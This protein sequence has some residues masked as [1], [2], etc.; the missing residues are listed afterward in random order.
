MF[1][2]L[3]FKIVKKKRGNAS[4]SNRMIFLK[5]ITDATA[6]LL[7][8]WSAYR[9]STKTL[10]LW[11]AEKYVIAENY[12]QPTNP[13]PLSNSRGFLPAPGFR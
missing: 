5:H 8:R 2:T 10:E 1:F 12:D 4:A 6:S 13:S 11:A 9:A 7:S 3:D